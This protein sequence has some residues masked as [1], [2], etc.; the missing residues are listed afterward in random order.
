MDSTAANEKLLALLHD[1]LMQLM[2]VPKRLESDH[3]DI[4]LTRYDSTTATENCLYHP[5]IALVVGGDKCAFYGEKEVSYGKG[6]Y[7]ILCSDMPGVFHITE[8][9]QDYPFLSISLRLDPLVVRTLLANC[10]CDMEFSS[11]GQASICKGIASDDLLMTFYRLLQLFDSKDEDEFLCNMIVK[12]M[13][14]FA[15]QSPLGERLCQFSMPGTRDNRIARAIA[16]MRKN[17]REQIHMEEL[18]RQVNLAPSTF[19]KYFREVTSLSP[20]QFQKHLRLNEA[21]RLL[22]I[23]NMEARAAAP[24]VGYESESQFSRE[25]KR[26]FGEPPIKNTA[27]NHT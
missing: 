8:A 23:G 21:R 24:A 15:L 27:K 10:Q 9:S 14:Y 13:H 11:S 5:M 26:H 6:E 25:Y 12:E 19:N 20:L 3:G 2:P 22:L 16:Y 17:F 1:K 18:A 4:A 7:V